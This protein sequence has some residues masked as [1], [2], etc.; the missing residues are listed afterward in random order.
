MLTLPT[1]KLH[2]NAE[3]GVN[4]ESDLHGNQRSRRNMEHSMLNVHTMDFHVKLNMDFHDTA[5]HENSMLRT[6]T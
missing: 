4:M 5:E 1:W 3:H 2:V 6:L